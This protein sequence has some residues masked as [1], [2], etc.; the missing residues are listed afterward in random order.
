MSEIWKRSSGTHERD[1]CAASEWKGILWKA[2]ESYSRIRRKLSSAFN[3]RF[4]EDTKRRLILYYI[5]QT[6]LH[7]IRTLALYLLP[8]GRNRILGHFKIGKAYKE[9]GK[10][11]F[12]KIEQ[13]KVSI[14][15]PCYNQ[16]HYTYR[17]LQ[18]I[19]AHTSQEENALRSDYCRWC[20]HRRYEGFASLFGEPRHCPK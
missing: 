3:R 11:R 15:I 8:D 6:F 4:P 5:A 7:P 16:I 14:V 2:P 9:G 10:V 17:C 1:S 19:L 20:F 13:P 12:A 18:S